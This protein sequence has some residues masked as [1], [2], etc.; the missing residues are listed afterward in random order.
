[1]GQSLAIRIINI[2]FYLLF[3]FSIVLGIIFFAVNKNEEPLIIWS[4]ALSIVAIG[5]TVLFGLANIFK[6]K[7]SFISSL[8]VFAAFAV[9]IA[10]SYGMSDS[11]IP[12]NAAGEIFDITE[13][14]SRW[15]GATLYMLY[16]LLGLSFFTLLYT[17]IRGAFR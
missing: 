10:L 7:K 14:V 11:T 8:V 13:T 9:L 12:T 3:A 2:L 4:Y 5:T 17:E 6:S 1:M 16:I 15:S